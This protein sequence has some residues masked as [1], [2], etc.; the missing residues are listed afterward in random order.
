M[1]LGKGPRLPLQLAQCD[2][3]LRATAAAE[4][5][6][7]CGST[8]KVTVKI[9]E[10]GWARIAITTGSALTGARAFDMASPASPILS[11]DANDDSG[12]LTAGAIAGIACGAGALFLGAAALFVI[13]WR[14][15]RRYDREDN[16]DS[17]SF[18]EGGLRGNMAPA[19]TYTLDY[20]MDNPQHHEGE[21]ASSYTYSPEKA[22][23]S[24]SPMS[25]PDAASAMPTHPAYIPRALVRGSS[26]PSNR[27]IATA[28]PPPFPSPPFPSG[29][30]HPKTQP[31]DAMIQAYLGAA[32][33]RTTSTTTTS[34][35][36]HTY[37]NT[38][39]NPNHRHH[40]SDSSFGLPIQSAPLSN[41]SQSQSRQNSQP[42]LTLPSLTS[43]PH[44][45][46]STDASQHPL[47][48][49][50][51]PAPQPQTTR[52]PRAYLPPRLNL[53]DTTAQMKRS[54][55]DKPL[56]GKEATTIS[57]PLAF[58]HLVHP[59]PVAAAAAPPQSQSR[60]R[61]GRSN[62]D[63]DADDLWGGEDGYGDES[64]GGGGG[65]ESR[66]T[67]R[68][69]ALSGNAHDGGS[70]QGSGSGGGGKEKEKGKKHGRKR[71]DRNS[72]GGYGGNRHYAEIEIGR[73]S[74][75]W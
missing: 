65:G 57:G 9:S 29:G 35:D 47:H 62:N 44:S 42:S 25:A 10:P 66:R 18:D 26:T 69:R 40:E 51:Q 16:S 68:S 45:A 43:P 72:G 39:T 46:S 12:T 60:S 27:S 58:P 54:K 33:A 15:Q 55:T 8:V 34:Q 23:Y 63:H 31:P 4:G 61:W 70:G 73:G 22:S 71:S 53:A 38:N 28:S 7:E 75:I 14:R 56:S 6:G 37:S 24:F 67:F 11:R 5:A 13:Y 2:Q 48:P 50:Q 49:H 19:V 17:E 3:R 32:T 1:V 64:G 36:S 21:Q 59:P 41:Q 52:K 30:S 74:D 20:K